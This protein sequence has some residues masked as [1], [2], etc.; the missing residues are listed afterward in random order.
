MSNSVIQARLCEFL[1]WIFCEDSLWILQARILECVAFPFPRGSSQPRDW[2]LVSQL[3]GR[4]FTSWATG[5]SETTGVG[6]LSLL[7][8]SRS[9]QPRNH[10][11]VC[12]IASRFFTNWAMREAQERDKQ[13]KFPGIYI[14]SKNTKQDLCCQDDHCG[15]QNTKQKFK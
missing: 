8:P 11:G 10:T 14:S 4:F 2:I 5:K 6:S 1:L 15:I 9:S 7:Q 13:R 12:C 3:A